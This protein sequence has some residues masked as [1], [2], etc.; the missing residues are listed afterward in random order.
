MGEGCKAR[1]W[2][3]WG[4]IKRVELIDCGAGEGGGF[5]RFQMKKP[6]NMRAPQLNLRTHYSLCLGCSPEFFSK[7]ITWIG[8][9]SA[10][11]GI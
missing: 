11:N 7:E 10:P 1:C 3:L 5:R 8:S 9:V 2:V 6:S 4:E